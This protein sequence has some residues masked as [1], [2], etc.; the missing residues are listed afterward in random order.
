MVVVVLAAAAVGARLHAEADAWRGPPDADD[1]LRWM[2]SGRALRLAVLR[3]D[4][5]AADLLWLRAVGMFGEKYGASGGDAAWLRWL[6]H[7]VD[8]VTD[9][10]PRFRSAYVHGGTLLRLFPGWV[11]QSTLVFAK[12]AAAL[13]DRWEFPFN[14]SMNYYLHEGDAESASR[15][16][17]QA[18]VI[19]GSPFYLRSLAASM[20]DEA[21]QLDTALAFVRQ[22]LT[23]VADP[24]VK[25]ALEVKEQEIRYRIGVREVEAARARFHEET[26][27]DAAHPADLV[28]GAIPRLPEEPLGGRWIFGPD[29]SAAS[30]RYD[31]W[32]EDVARRTGLGPAAARE[33]RPAGGTAEGEPAGAPAP[34]PATP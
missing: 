22:E 7:L 17:R 21:N 9:L 30:D 3:Y 14:I 26:G 6:Y 8:L 10:D 34:A 28:P 19:P 32:L 33:A 16:M 18:S 15:Y 24:R 20:L 27:R 29:G 25:S 5:V 11:T 1:E 12:G 31:A 2:P 13:P 4:N 23:Q